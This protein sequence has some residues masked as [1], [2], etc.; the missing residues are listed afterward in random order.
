MARCVN[1]SITGSAVTEDRTGTVDICAFSVNSLEKA[2]KKVLLVMRDGRSK[3][4]IAY[5]RSHFFY[6]LKPGSFI[7]KE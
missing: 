3:R 2:L 5:A 7:L 1:I 6:I 4:V